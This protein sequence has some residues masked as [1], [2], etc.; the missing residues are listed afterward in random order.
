MKMS[1][2]MICNNTLAKGTIAKVGE[3]FFKLT[4][5]EIAS[6]CGISRDSVMAAV[7]E[8]TSKPIA[9]GEQPCCI[10]ECYQQRV[11][12]GRTCITP[13]YAMFKGEEFDLY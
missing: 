8:L 11:A 7:K 5:D 3:S 4:I 9:V 13:N 2:L 10:K 6:R 1:E 12:A